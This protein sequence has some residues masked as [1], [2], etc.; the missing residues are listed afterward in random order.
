MKQLL[1]PRL[2][3]AAVALMIITPLISHRACAQ[4]RGGGN[5]GPRV[6]SPEVRDGTVTFR[7]LAPR[8]EAVKLSGSDMPGVGQGKE[9]TKNAEGVWEVTLE[10][11]PG[12]YRYVFNVDGI[13][14][15]D[16]RNPS[17]SESVGNVWSLVGVPGLAWM[18]TQPVP[19]GVVAEVTYYS[20][21]LRRFRRMHVYTPPGYELGK[22][23]YPV[24]YLLHGAGD[25]DDSWSTVGRAGFILDNLIA[26]KKAKP[27]IVVMTAGHTG[28]MIPGAPRPAVDEF[29]E[30]FT[31]DVMPY[32]ES[33]FRVNKDRGS[34]ALAGLSMGGGQTL[35]IGIPHLDKFGY[36]GVFS[37]GVFGITGGNRPGSTNAPAGPTFEERHHDRLNDAKLKK[38]LRLFWFATGKDDFLVATSRATVEMFKKHDFDVVYRETD[39]AHTWIKWREYLQEFTPQLFR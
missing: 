10:A 20:T 8:A 22:G 12:Y 13:N 16:P 39:G 21:A 9:M 1:F 28:P 5:Q 33:H 24:F 7:I 15:V 35:N 25:S 37:S 6:V 38:G 19:R 2:R 14:V 3:V 18:D 23:K 30:D 31:K 4:A 29:S 26:E 27:M 32:V 17:T 34:R 36:L 11:S